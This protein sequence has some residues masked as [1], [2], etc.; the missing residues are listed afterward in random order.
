MTATQEKLTKQ[1]ATA[2]AVTTFCGPFFHALKPDQVNMTVSEWADSYRVLTSESAAEPGRYETSRTPYLKEIMDVLGPQDPCHRVVFKKCSQV[3][4]TESANNWIGY[5]IDQV[6]GPF[7]VVY[8]TDKVIEK[9]NTQRFNPLFRSVP[10]LAEKIAQKKSRSDTNTKF[11]KEFPGGLLIMG[12]ANAPSNFN[13]YPIRFVLADEVDRFPLDCG[14]EGD[15]V[16]LIEGRTK[17]FARNKKQFFISTPVDDETSIIDRLYKES[18]QRVYMVPCPHCGAFQKLI[19]EQL[20]WEQGNY[21]DVRYECRHCNEKFEEQY[22]TS[23]LEAGY[24]EPQNPKEKMCKGYH[25]N[26]LYSPLGWESWNDIAKKFDKW[27]ENR[28]PL[29]LK[30]FINTSLGETWKELGGTPDWEVCYRKREKYKIGVVPKGAY[31]LTAGIDVQHDRL[32][33]EVVGWGENQES[34]SIE[35]RIFKGDTTQPEVW[36]D[37]S[38]YC[39]KLFPTDEGNK[40]AISKI[41]IDSGDQ[42]QIVYKYVRDQADSRLF[43]IK[44]SERGDSILGRPKRVDIRDGDVITHH[45]ALD[46]WPVSVNI[47]KEELFARLQL[48][49]PANKRDVHPH[50][51]CHFPDYDMEFFKQLTSEVKQVVFKNGK[52]RI[53]WKKLRPRNEAL[54]RRVYARAAANLAGID[55]FASDDWRE[56]KH[57]VIDQ[58]A[59]FQ[60]FSADN[61][62]VAPVDELPGNETIEVKRRESSFWT[63]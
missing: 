14:G 12:G 41:A 43:A 50:G 58:Q 20:K 36:K 24:W 10:R 51:Y 28:D 40:I 7:L 16:E 2:D 23:M 60:K 21:D 33:I 48:E 38:R 42:T 63:N 61:D 15:P 57:A 11:I 37:L 6:P 35:E 30:T 1:K 5:V 8:P 26:A 32:E 45:D 39:R 34:W 52:K 56:L 22:K 47:V 53:I 59:R 19:F 46:C 27:R 3:G 9:V 31:L 44:G 49:A 17:T 29:L 18:D 4:A 13:S 55:D 62:N 54:D 25:I